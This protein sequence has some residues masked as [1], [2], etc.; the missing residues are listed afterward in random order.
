MEPLICKA[1]VLPLN[2]RPI[3]SCLPAQQSK[4]FRPIDSVPPS[5]W[6]SIINHEALVVRLQ[7]LAG[8]YRTVLECLAVSAFWLAADWFIGQKSLYRSRKVAMN[9]RRLRCSHCPAWTSFCSPIWSC[10]FQGTA[11]LLLLY[12]QPG[13]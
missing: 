2:N 10:P 13:E 8:I 11:T 9:Q 7:D 5:L 6:L 12:L 3:P 1:C 4:H